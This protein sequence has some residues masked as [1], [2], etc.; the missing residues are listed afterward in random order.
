MVGSRRYHRNLDR[1]I[2]CLSYGITRW[3]AESPSSNGES[4]TPNSLVSLVAFQA[5]AVRCHCGCVKLMEWEGGGV[6]VRRK[7]K[8]WQKGEEGED[9]HDQESGND[10]LHDDNCK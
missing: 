8:E 1:H 7:R 3:L 6:R 5:A 10:W 9:L 4:L 2:T